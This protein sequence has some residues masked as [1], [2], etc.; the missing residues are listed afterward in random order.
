MKPLV[1][2]SCI[3]VWHLPYGLM[4]IMGKESNL[5]QQYDLTSRGNNISIQDTILRLVRIVR[6]MIEY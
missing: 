4:V 5:V 3:V 6:K 2:R 1:E